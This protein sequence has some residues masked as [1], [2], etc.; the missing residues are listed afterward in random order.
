[1]DEKIQRVETCVF[2]RDGGGDWEKGLLLNEGKLGIIDSKG[3]KVETIHNFE[4]RS[5]FAAELK[6]FVEE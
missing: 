3:N 6:Y 5:A 4:T 1:M 2:Q